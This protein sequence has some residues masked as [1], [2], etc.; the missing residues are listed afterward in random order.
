MKSAVKTAWAHGGSDFEL[1]FDKTKA[2]AQEMKEGALRVLR[3]LEN[4]KSTK[5]ARLDWQRG[6]PIGL[7][8]AIPSKPIMPHYHHHGFDVRS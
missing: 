4:L 8:P 5:A 1:R 6:F 7:I 2:Q 3:A